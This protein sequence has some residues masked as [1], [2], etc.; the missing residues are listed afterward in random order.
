MGNVILNPAKPGEGAYDSLSPYVLL[1]R[2]KVCLLL[3]KSHGSDESFTPTY[4]PSHR[5]RRCSG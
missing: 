2:V 4:D 3:R 1:A 5:L